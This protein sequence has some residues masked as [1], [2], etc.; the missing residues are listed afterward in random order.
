MAAAVCRAVAA[1]QHSAATI[2]AAH[3]SERVDIGFPLAL[4]RS[5]VRAT[6]CWAAHGA[7]SDNL[8]AQGPMG[9]QRV[10][11]QSL[12]VI[13]TGLRPQISLAYS[14]MVR[15]EEKR[16]EWAMLRTTI[17]HHTSGCRQMRAASF[18]MA[19]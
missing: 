13:G 5:K 7:C 19:T 16:P 18:W 2:A 6:V 4:L 1:V 15:S 9:R 8:S 17:G 12:S 11:A 14:L 10:T 3:R